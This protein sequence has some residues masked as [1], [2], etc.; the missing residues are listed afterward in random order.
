MAEAQEP[1]TGESC[2][3]CGAPVEVVTSGEGTS[4][5]ERVEERQLAEAREELKRVAAMAEH[6]ERRL[7]AK[8]D[9][10]REAEYRARARLEA[11][12]KEAAQWKGSFDGMVAVEKELRAEISRLR[13]EGDQG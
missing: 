12:E 9:E 11:V 10:A 8:C 1:R 7:L 4:H 3:A 2:P 13:D 6:E 5:Y